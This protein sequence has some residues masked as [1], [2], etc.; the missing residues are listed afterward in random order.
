MASNDFAGPKGP[1]A[2]LVED[3]AEANQGVGGGF[4]DASFSMS[5]FEAV[6][7]KY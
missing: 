5:E 2:R 1:S 7:C 3:G 4:A 6:F